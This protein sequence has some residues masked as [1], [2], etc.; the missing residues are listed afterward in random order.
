MIGIAVLA[1][2][3]FHPG[4]IFGKTWANANFSVRGRKLV[5]PSSRSSDASGEEGMKEGR[6]GVR[7]VGKR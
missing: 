6:F 4:F 2:S 5:Q 7:E 3:F 1:L